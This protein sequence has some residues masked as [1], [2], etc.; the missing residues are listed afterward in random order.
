MNLQELAQQIINDYLVE[1]FENIE[2]FDELASGDPDAQDLTS[3]DYELLLQTMGN[4]KLV[5]VKLV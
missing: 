5:A 1:A 3:G 2:D 4:V